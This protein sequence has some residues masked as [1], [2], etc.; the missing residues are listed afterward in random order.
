MKK[1]TQAARV[2]GSNLH[3]E[4]EEH[5][6]DDTGSKSNRKQFT[7]GARRTGRKLYMGSKRNKREKREKTQETRGNE[8]RDTGNKSNRKKK[9]SKTKGIG[10]KR[11]MK[12][13]KGQSKQENEEERDT[14]NKRNLKAVVQLEFLGRKRNFAG[15]FDKLAHKIRCTKKW[16][17]CNW[18]RVL[19][20]VVYI[21]LHCNLLHMYLPHVRTYYS[22]Y[23]TT[24]ISWENL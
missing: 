16:Q 17:L 24:E 6:E 11:H 2:T 20:N 3:G 14:G 5:E 23:H 9:H 8:G 21:I 13:M 15:N 1:M 10:V 22:I 19:A 4:Q 12:Q 18:K 7:W